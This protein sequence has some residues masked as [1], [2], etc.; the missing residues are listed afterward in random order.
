MTE[1]AP[2]RP[3]DDAEEIMRLDKRV[4]AGI[5]VG[6]TLVGTVIGAFAFPP[7]WGLAGQLGAGAML[8]F[9][10]ALILFANRYL[11]S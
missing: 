8:G 9:W 2:E 1:D 7:D 10:S 6:F 4:L 5:F 11:A 3:P